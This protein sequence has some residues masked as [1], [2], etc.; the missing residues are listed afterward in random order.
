N[1]VWIVNVGDLKPVEFPISFFLD[2][3][4]NPKKIEADQ[5][6]K[7]TEDWTAKQFGKE[8]AVEIATII[9][10]YSKYNARRKPELLDQNTY[11]LTN[12]HEFEKLVAD[13]NQLKDQA[14]KL[15]Q[16]L[17]AAY[18]DAY[19]ELVLHPVLAC[20]NLNEMYFE[21]AKNKYYVTAHN[22]TA[23]NNAADKVKMLYEKDQQISNYYND[24]LAHGKWSH[25][26]DQT[27]IGYTYWQQPNANKMPSVT[28]LNS[29]STKNTTLL[30]SINHQQKL[31]GDYADKNS[32]IAIDAE[33][34]SRVK[35]SVNIKWTIIPDYGN[36]LSGVTPLPVTTPR[37]KLGANTPCLEY[38]IS[39]K[40]TGTVAVTTFVGP[41]LDFRNQD[42]LYYA[43]SI[44]NE[45]PQLVNIATKVDGQ[46]W[47]AAVSNN[48]RK[49]VT[50]HQISKPGKHV[51]KYWM[52]DPAVVVE[53]LVVDFG[54]LKPSYLGPPESYQSK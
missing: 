54:G 10:K 23:A 8:N 15:N 36:T 5:L 1:Q 6:Q 45:Q 25:M 19:Y 22:A 32:Y 13:Y 47:A 41:T 46:E 3:A 16:N 37:I 29:D 21:A 52:V 38:D 11:S 20:A 35:N 33:H 30:P 43:I 7:Y 48:V 50:K 14:E 4:W 42:G 53:K 34:F 26:M 12:Y 44:D 27:H 2:Y 51:L 17:P 28:R 40:D 24:T 49:L 31:N 18:K 39:L 9:S